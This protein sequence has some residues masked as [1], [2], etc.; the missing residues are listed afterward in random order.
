MSRVE[1]RVDKWFRENP[2]AEFENAV[3]SLICAN[4]KIKRLEN[5]NKLLREDNKT[6]KS[7]PPFPADDIRNSMVQ[8][9]KIKELE[10]IIE[11]LKNKEN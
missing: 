1:Q 7:I 5:K 8:D 3:Y 6:L 10:T 11:E 9:N 2:Y 4:D